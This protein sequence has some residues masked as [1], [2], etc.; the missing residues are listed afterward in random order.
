[1]KGTVSVNFLNYDTLNVSL[2]YCTLEE[3]KYLTVRMDWT[4]TDI[5]L[6]VG[7]S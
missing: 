3:K 1:M 5:R 6:V 7:D 4:L 2:K